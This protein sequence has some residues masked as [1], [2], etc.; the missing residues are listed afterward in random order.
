MRYNDAV[1]FT[2]AYPVTVLGTLMMHEIK[3][4]DNKN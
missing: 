3:T 1:Q 4:L 2:L